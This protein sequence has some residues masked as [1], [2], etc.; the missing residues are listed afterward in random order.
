M[1]LQID[2]ALDSLLRQLAEMPEG[3]KSYV[4]SRLGLSS[5]EALAPWLSSLRPSGF[6]PE[7]S[8]ILKIIASGQVP[9]GVTPAAAGVLGEA[10]DELVRGN[11]SRDTAV[12]RA[13]PRG[14]L[15]QV[16]H[17]LERGAD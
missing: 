3:D 17:I 6:S 14:L 13:R 7:L 12:R 1:N 2:P 5:E 16:R 8:E 9:P 15:A 10:A 4:L 11:T